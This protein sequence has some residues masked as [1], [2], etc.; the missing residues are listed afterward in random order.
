MALET[1][2]ELGHN[3]GND[4]PAEGEIVKNIKLVFWAFLLVLAVFW[5]LADRP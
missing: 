2:A 4:R 1:P 5:L 3:P